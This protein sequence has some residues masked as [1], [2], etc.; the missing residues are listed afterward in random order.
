M[1]LVWGHLDDPCFRQP[2]AKEADRLLRQFI[3]GKGGLQ[4]NPGVIVGSWPSVPTGCSLQ[5][6][7]NTHFNANPF[8]DNKRAI[9]PTYEF[10]SVCKRQYKLGPPK[11]HECPLGTSITTAAECH[12][13]ESPD[14]SLI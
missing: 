1:V 4:G 6:L 7:T 5:S 10:S 11:Q 13:T 3:G 9:A 8:S 14:E 12:L 2:S